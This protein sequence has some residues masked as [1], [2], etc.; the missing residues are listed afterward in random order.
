MAT[1]KSFEELEIW[2]TARILNKE[3]IE[4]VK[5]D[6]VQKDFRF[7]DQIRAA[8]GSIMDNI[9]EGF[10]RESRLEFINFLSYSKGSIGEVKSQLYRGIDMNYWAE[11]D[12][13]ELKQK[14]ET[15]SS[16]IANFIKYLNRSQTKGTKFKNRT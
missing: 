12:V 3:I 14:F 6:A 13:E 16:H 2:R 10:E 9:A 7:K 4:L 11:N 15:L 8:S 1:I 5:L